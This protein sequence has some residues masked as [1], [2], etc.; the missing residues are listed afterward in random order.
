MLQ[1][2]VNRFATLTRDVEMKRYEIPEG[3]VA[4]VVATS[5]TAPAGATVRVVSFFLDRGD[6]GVTDQLEGAYAHG[7]R[8][9]PE[10]LA[11][12]RATPEDA[13]TVAKCGACGHEEPIRMRCAK[14]G[15]LLG[16]EC[17]MDDEV[18]SGRCFNCQPRG[19]SKK[20]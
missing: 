5:H 7:C 15:R 11:H 14:C 16:D 2:L 4:P 6:V 1:A 3:G 20:R 12:L 8:V 18:R 13:P 10:E 17:V 9:M 19:G